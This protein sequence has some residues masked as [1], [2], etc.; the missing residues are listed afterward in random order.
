MRWAGLLAAIGVSA[1][2]MTAAPSAS[3]TGGTATPIQHIVVLMQSGH[4]FDNYFG[5]YPG[6][7]GIPGGTCL[8]ANTLN[9]KAHGCVRP[10]H[11][12]G[13]PSSDLDHGYGTWARQYDGGRMDGFVSAYRRLGLSGATAMGLI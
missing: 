5:T 12:D 10:Y 8:P 7:D 13:A 3:A 11:L 1:G 9:P 6:A 2:L 4:S